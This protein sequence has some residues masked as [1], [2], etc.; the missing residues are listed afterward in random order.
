M[1]TTVKKILNLFLN[2]SF[3]YLLLLHHFFQ[4]LCLNC[5]F[6]NSQLWQHRVRFHDITQ[7]G[8]QFKTLIAYF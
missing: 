2:V 8:A 7:N 4:K 3:T 1:F 5:F 6:N